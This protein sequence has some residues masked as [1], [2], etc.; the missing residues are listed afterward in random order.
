MSKWEYKVEPFGRDCGYSKLHTNWLC[1]L[2]KQGW[3]LVSIL[4]NGMALFHLFKREVI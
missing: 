2:G 4:D 3:E 1:E